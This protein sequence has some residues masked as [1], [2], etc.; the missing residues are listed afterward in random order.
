MNI[1]GGDYIS[2]NPRNYTYTDNSDQELE[3]AEPSVTPE[4]SPDSDK[5]RTLTVEQ[6]NFGYIVRV[7]CHSFAIETHEKV[8]KLVGEYLANPSGTERKWY[9]NTFE[10]KR[11]V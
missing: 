10:L 7:G 4:E 5:I 6:L 3:V 1:D 2:A 9:A 11:K 8:S